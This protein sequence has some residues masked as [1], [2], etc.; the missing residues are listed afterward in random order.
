MFFPL[1]FWGISLLF[2]V[3]S[4][5]LLTISI[6]ISF[7]RGRLILFFDKEKLE[8]ATIFFVSLFL[9]TVAIRIV[10]ALILPT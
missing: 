2:A 8:K 9:I 10:A 5:F 7:Q 1:D 6:L 3:M 4:F